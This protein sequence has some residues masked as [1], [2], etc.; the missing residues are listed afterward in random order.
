M[1]VANN[2][3]QQFF[4]QPA[5]QSF[6]QTWQQGQQQ[7]QQGLAQPA[8]QGWQQPQ[9]ANPWGQQTPQPAGLPF[10]PTAPQYQA[11]LITINNCPVNLGVLQNQVHPNLLSCLVPIA[12]ACIDALQTRAGQNSL[13][14]FLYNQMGANNY[15]NQ[16]FLGLVKSVAELAEYNAQCGVQIE[17]A[18][19]GAVDLCLQFYAFNNLQQYP[20]LQQYV[21][22]SMVNNLQALANKQSQ[23]VQAMAQYQQQKQMR[24]QQ[25]MGFNGGQVYQQP[26][27]GWQQPLQQAQQAPQSWHNQSTGMFS[28][29]TQAA[30][31]Q[32]ERSNVVQSW[33]ASAYSDWRNQVID[34]PAQQ[35]PQQPQPTQQAQPRPEACP[36]FSFNA[37]VMTKQQAEQLQS[38]QPAQQPGQRQHPDVVN[39]INVSMYEKVYQHDGK[40]MVK[41]GEP[42]VVFKMSN[43]WPITPKA[44]RV[45]DVFYILHENGD[46]E[47]VIK[48]LTY[49]EKMERERHYAMMSAQ[50]PKRYPAPNGTPEEIIAARERMLKALSEPGAVVYEPDL[51]KKAISE[52]EVVKDESYAVVTASDEAWSQADI[53]L[54]LADN[55]TKKCEAYIKPALNVT[56]IVAKCDVKELV[57]DLKVSVTLEQC[58]GKLK[59]DTYTINSMKG[60]V[61]K[62][63]KRAVHG[64][65]DRILTESVN[66]YL[67]Y[68]L[69]LPQ[70][71]IDS[72][73][74]DAGDLIP[75][76]KDNYPESFSKALSENQK[77]I[78]TSVLSTTSDD[79][80]G[81]E[82]DESMREQHLPT[83]DVGKNDPVFLYRKEVYLSVNLFAAEITEQDI[84]TEEASPVFKDNAPALY[85]LCEHAFDC[86]NEDDGAV[87]GY[88]I[89]TLDDQVFVFNRS[90]LVPSTFIIG[91]KK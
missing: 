7:P 25:G 48:K 65:L 16:I 22:P 43:R 81:S 32:Q 1:Y 5:A 89:K 79:F 37:P 64:K 80:D 27:Q 36:A 8:Q 54:A 46:M 24:A 45:A 3:A 39:G 55:D 69:G 52:D 23:V 38:M 6:N 9:A 58:A 77:K 47:P 90:A 51:R 67:A 83:D 4:N 35:V 18:I 12:V 14:M 73:E 88:Y 56:P 29:Q 40:V 53:G 10:S 42:G 82:F 74:E 72:F 60:G 15:N 2:N 59:V 28:S 19:T 33:E 63:Q 30:P 68:S 91:K 34:T 70:I 50:D 85:S 17:Q 31:V 75:Y 44:T 49:E 21:D 61:T 71:R 57:D 13:R 87:Y 86:L 78:I 41:Y 20:A 76:L 84:E 66:H 62:R 11:S 26:N